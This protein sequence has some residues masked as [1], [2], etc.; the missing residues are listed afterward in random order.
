MR[1]FKDET[2]KRHDML[3]VLRFDEIRKG[4]PFFAC[5]CDCGREVYVRGANLRS[6]NTTSCGC[7]H[8]KLPRRRGSIQ[9]QIRCGQRVWGKVE[10][11]T[12]GKTLCLTTCM[13]CGRIGH[14]TERILC[15]RRAL[16]CE[17]YRPTHNSWR[18]MI[19]RCTNRNHPQFADYGGR[20]I[21]VSERWRGNFWRLVEDM[22]IR[23]KG[24]SIDRIKG[25][26]GY[27]LGNCRWSTK[28][29]Q[30]ANRRKPRRKKGAS[31]STLVS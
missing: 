2:G 7:S 12:S 3:T 30:A 11:P 24:M 28:K 8:R 26:E 13:S 25:D 1:R 19:E 22:R 31:T 6:G 20:G 10:D 29:E 5:R 15:N 17:C 21:R 4:Q 23:P 27:H 9:M 16:T 14:Y 18:K